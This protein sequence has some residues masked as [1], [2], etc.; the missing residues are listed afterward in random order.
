[1][2]VRTIAATDHR[3]RR[4]IFLHGFPGFKTRQNQDYAAKLQ[5]HLGGR[6]D[7]LFYSGL[8]VATGVF[9]FA[10]CVAEVRS[11]VSEICRSHKAEQLNLVGHSWGGFLTLLLCN[12]FPDQIKNIA[13]ISP[14]LAFRAAH[15]ARISLGQTKDEY[16]NMQLAP[17]EELTAEFGRV[18]DQYP[19]DQ[20]IKNLNPA[21]RV[22]FIQARNDLITRTEVA[23]EKRGLF[24]MKLNYHEIDTD[25]SFLTEREAVIHLLLE[26]CKS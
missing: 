1:M 7:V 6:C 12:E 21:L 19:V 24:P 18:A 8:G 5:D 3:Q 4:T 15:D 9:N 17:L 20:L 16:P 10:S 14:L 25:H 22:L 11:Y 13:L 26:H 2:D 23:H